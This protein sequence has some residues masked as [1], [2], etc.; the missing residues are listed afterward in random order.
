MKTAFISGISGQDGAYLALHLLNDNYRV[1]GGI[2]RNSSPQHLQRLKD[3]HIINYIE[4]VPFELSDPENITETIRSYQ[5]DQFYNLAAQSFVG[6]SFAI[7]RYTSQVTGLAVVDILE[8]IRRYSP[9]TRFYQ[10]SSSEMYGHDLIK[11]AYNELTPHKSRSP[12]GAAKSFAHQ[13]TVNYRESY[14]LH[15]SCGILFNH[16]SPYRG[17]QFVTQKVVHG[18]C[19]FTKTQ[20]TI[21]LGTLK[22]RRDWGHA[23]DYTAAMKLIVENPFADDYVVAT[24][25]T[26][27]IEDL[28]NTAAICHTFLTNDKLQLESIVNIN[29]DDSKDVLFSNLHNKFVFHVPASNPRPTELHWLQGDCSKIRQQLNWRPVY[30]FETM[31]NEMVAYKLKR[32]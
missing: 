19:D 16:E 20:Q 3:L 2:R 30:D 14:N 10:A 13:I 6:D 28:I 32:G 1:V 21:E 23:F 8:A 26:H 25:K 24:G 17:P 12:Y 29:D 15:A 18:I 9:G 27:S 11:E 7:P 4:F 5:F 22:S 31:I